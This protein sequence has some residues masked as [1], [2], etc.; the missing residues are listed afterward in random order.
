MLHQ[1]LE[2]DQLIIGLDT[3]H[4]MS[5]VIL[6]VVEPRG[7][8]LRDEIVECSEL[9]YRR[10]RITFAVRSGSAYSDKCRSSL[11]ANEMGFV[12]G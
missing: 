5:G 6:E 8:R 12:R 1:T 2:S 10:G 3:K 9:A 7:A 4:N 11:C